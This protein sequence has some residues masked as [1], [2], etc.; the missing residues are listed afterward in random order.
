M[1]AKDHGKSSA[2][3]QL[4]LLAESSIGF[5]LTVYHVKLL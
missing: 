4:P 1:A 3:G 2:V 5:L